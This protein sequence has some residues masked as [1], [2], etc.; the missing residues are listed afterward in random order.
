MA[1]VAYQQVLNKAA[2]IGSGAFGTALALQLCRKGTQVSIYA[3]SAEA[4]TDFNEKRENS[5]YLP[6]VV[7]PELLK[8]TSDVKE[9]VLD[10]ELVILAIP[11]Q[12]LRDFLVANRAI[13]PLNVPIVASAKGI[14]IKTLQTPYEIMEDELPGKYSKNFAVL[15]GPSFAKEMCA[16]QPT[17]VA[18]ASLDIEVAKRVQAAMSTPVFRCYT[19]DDVMG[20]EIA[21]A[22]KNVLAIAAG[23]SDGLGFGNN[24]RA[25]LVC[26]GLQEMTRLAKAMGSSGKCMSGLAGV[27]DLL[28]TCSSTLSRNFTVG[29]RIALGETIE[30]ILATST[31]VAEGVASAQSIYELG[32]QK[33]VRLPICNRV[34]E[35]L[36]KKK[37]IAD[38]L[39]DLQDSKPGSEYDDL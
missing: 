34:Y 30:H 38:A 39:R 27:G 11:T 5:K 12:F 37:P 36:Y 35:V 8:A 19:H 20:C 1:A 22:V 4:V 9:C 26:R 6:G 18:I 13:W 29:R 28:L 3:R 15:A 25:A 21:G 2:V 16:N 7:I 23:A 24:A 32:N 33:N 17:N 14:E 10:A 31:S